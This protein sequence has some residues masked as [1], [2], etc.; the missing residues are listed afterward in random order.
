[1]IHSARSSR[2][3]GSIAATSQLIAARRRAA[4]GARGTSGFALLIVVGTCRSLVAGALFADFVETRAAT[5]ARSWRDARRRR[6]RD[7]A[8]R[9]AA[10]AP[11]VRDGDDARL[12]RGVRR[13]RRARRWRWCPGVSR[14]GATID[15][16]ACAMGLERAAAARFSFFWR[17]RRCAA[18]FG[19]DLLEVAASRRRPAPLIAVGFVMAFGRRRLRHGQ[20]RSCAI[21]RGRLRA[22]SPG[23]ASRSAAAARR[24]RLGWLMRRCM[25][26]CAGV[27]SP[28][29]SSPCR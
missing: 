4:A 22:V 26:G 23:T 7:A 27:S 10:A 12:R 19:H 6:R 8:R 28:G 18:A 13:R 21:V 25:R 3:C 20:V 5:T 11:T 24:V 1:M 14:S 9:A 2:W 15:R 16:R 29:S 17:C